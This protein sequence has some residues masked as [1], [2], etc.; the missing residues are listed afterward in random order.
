[1]FPLNPFT[2][3]ALSRSHILH[4]LKHMHNHEPTSLRLHLTMTL[5]HCV[6]FRNSHMRVP[7][8]ARKLHAP[9]RRNSVRECVMSIIASYRF[10]ILDSYLT[11]ILD[12]S[13]ISG[14]FKVCICFLYHF[15]VEVFNAA[16]HRRK[17]MITIRIAVTVSDC[18]RCASEGAP[19]IRRCFNSAFFHFVYVEAGCESESMASLHGGRYDA[20]CAGTVRI[21]STI[22]VTLAASPKR[23]VLVLLQ[24]CKVKPPVEGLL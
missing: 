10:C 21:S 1:M 8:R 23:Q 3:R 11:R 13:S 12:R 15:G 22:Y 20:N 18:S 7:D 2:K 5:V 6:Q 17:H 14:F 9:S 4:K 16:I 24:S 19:T